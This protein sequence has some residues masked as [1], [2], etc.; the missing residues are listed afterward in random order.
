VV[1]GSNRAVT[2]EDNDVIQLWD[3][4]AGKK[5]EP[6][7]VSNSAYIADIALSPDGQRLAV[8]GE[9]GGLGG[10]GVTLWDLATRE[11]L[12]SLN[13]ESGQSVVVFS[14]DGKSVASGARSL[15]VWDSASGELKA[16]LQGH[17]ANIL[18]L[19]FSPDGTR[20]ASMSP[21]R[22]TRIWDLTTA[23]EALTLPLGGFGPLRLAFSPDGRYLLS[24]TAFRNALTFSTRALL[25]DPD[26][27]VALA[28]SRLT[29]WLTADECQ[30]FLHLEQCPPEP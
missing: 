3:L 10:A 24:S 2:G 12:V 21:D 22:T 28:E 11:P 16:T 15:F 4:T 20:L 18:Y 25:M 23:K 1:W 27:L 7:A 30:R 29:R 9:G 17:S 6:L 26:E 14:P 19:A 13:G 8:S 5:L